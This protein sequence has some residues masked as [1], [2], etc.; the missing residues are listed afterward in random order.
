MVTK[1]NMRPRVG[2][3]A[4]IIEEGKILL[5]KRIHSHG[6][7][8]WSPP[9]GHLEFGERVDDCVI[10]EVREETGLVAKKV[11][12]GPWTNDFFH[13]EQKHYISLF[14]IVTEFT[15][16]PL[17]LE[18][19]KCLQWK[20]FEIDNLPVPLFLPFENLIKKTPLKNLLFESS[21]T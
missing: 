18:P 6:S 9:G 11:I 4:L 20:W 19:D 21:I 5:G 8:T 2:V 3:A 14:M 1:L 7:E 12:A 10:R 17:V 16:K 15:G 13:K